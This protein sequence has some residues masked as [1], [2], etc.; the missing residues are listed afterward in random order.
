[1]S[2]WIF[3]TILKVIC[4]L[5]ALNTSGLTVN[6]KSVEF[7]HLKYSDNGTDEYCLTKQCIEESKILLKKMNLNAKP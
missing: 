5:S 1:M 3:E 6:G 4:V 7:D 2:S